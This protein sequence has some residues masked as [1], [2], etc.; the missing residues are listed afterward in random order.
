MWVSAI[1]SPGSR[2]QDRG[3]DA[4]YLVES[5]ICERREGKQD[6]TEVEIKLPCRFARAL[7]N[8]TE[9]SGMSIVHQHERSWTKM[10]KSLFSDLIQRLNSGSPGKGAPR[11]RQAL[12][13]PT[14]GNSV[15][16]AFYAA[17]QQVF[18][19]RGIWVEHL[20]IFS[21]H[22]TTRWLKTLYEP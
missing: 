6:W 17:R 18:P 2:H 15:L 7:A 1:G 22:Q 21:K 9:S 13:K 16:I 14:A 11:A 20:H 10:A 5:I 3:W 8:P 19:W 4:R 12:K